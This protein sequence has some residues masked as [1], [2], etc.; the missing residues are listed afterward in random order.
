MGSYEAFLRFLETRKPDWAAALRT[1]GTPDTGTDWGLAP[2]VWTRIAQES[3]REFGRLQHEFVDRTYYRPTL[4]LL[5]QRV[6]VGFE[7]AP[8]AIRE[9]IWST[10]VQHGPRAAAEIIDQAIRSDA[11]PSEIFGTALPELVSSVYLARGECFGGSSKPIRQAVRA[12]FEREQDA[13]L[14]M[15]ENSMGAELAT[16]A[17][18]AQ[19]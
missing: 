8:R 12:R 15:T 11:V 5:Y 6:G 4:R 7:G 17:P 16:Q 1:A 19:K 3:P 18:K 14:A 2:Y 13:I 10:A 9:M